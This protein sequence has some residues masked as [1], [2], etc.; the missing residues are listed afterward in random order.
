MSPTYAR[1]ER[2]DV[3]DAFA[4]ENDTGPGTLARYLRDYPQF[5]RELIDLGRELRRDVCEDVEPLSEQ[6]RKMIEAAWRHHAEAATRTAMVDP[7]AALSAPELREAAKR[8]DLPRQVLTAFR[9]R[10]VL[11]ETVPRH[12]LR[13]LA[14]AIHSTL[15]DLTA[16][17]SAPSGLTLARSYKADRQPTTSAAVSFEQILI[18]A[19]VPDDRRAALLLEAG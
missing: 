4:V 7:F 17:L 3:L 12:F 18:E 5:A 1:I 13:Q 11:V 16:S 15:D 9:E 10:R 6:E 14:E 19:G 2:E 8:L